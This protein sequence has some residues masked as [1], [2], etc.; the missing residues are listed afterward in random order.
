MFLSV[1]ETLFRKPRG[2]CLLSFHCHC[3]ESGV[4]VLAHEPHIIIVPLNS[5]SVEGSFLTRQSALSPALVALYTVF[6]TTG[7]IRL[8]VDGRLLSPGDKRETR[9]ENATLMLHDINV[10]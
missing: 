6:P 8:C 10:R 3:S 9:A 2:Q 5:S 4:S 1:P 7:Q